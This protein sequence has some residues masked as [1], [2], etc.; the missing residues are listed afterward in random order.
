MFRKS[1]S[2]YAPCALSLGLT[3][4]STGSRAQATY[5]FTFPTPA[6]QVNISAW[7]GNTTPTGGDPVFHRPV[8]GIGTTTTPTILSNTL[9]ASYTPYRTKNFTVGTGSSAIGTPGVYTVTTTGT[10]VNGPLPNADAPIGLIYRNSFNPAS[11]LTNLVWG[12]NTTPTNVTLSAGNYVFVVTTGFSGSSGPITATLT[13]PPVYAAPTATLTGTTAAP[14]ASALFNRPFANG[15]LPPTATD[16]TSGSSHYY[17]ADAFTVPADGLYELDSTAQTPAPWN[18]AIALYQGSFDPANPLTNCLEVS[19][20]SYSIAAPK[21]FSSLQYSLKAGVTYY[22]VTFAFTNTPG[23][24]G[25][26]VSTVSPVTLQTS[27]QFAGKPVGLL[28]T[29]TGNTTSQLNANRPNANSTLGGTLGAPP[30]TLSGSLVPADPHS[31]TSS[32]SGPV[33][34]TSTC[35][36]P[37][38]WNNWL[39]VYAGSFDISNP[40]TNILYSLDG[41]YSDFSTSPI[42]YAS[43]GVFNSVVS[44]TFNA[45]AGQVYTI[46]TTGNAAANVGSYRGTIASAPVLGAPVASFSGTLTAGSGGFG[47][48]R[49]NAG[50]TPSTA[51][52]TTSNFVIPSDFKSFTITTEG[53]YYITDTAVTPGQWSLYLI[54]YKDSFDGASP[55]TNAIAAVGADVNNV[56]ATIP[57]IH[58]TPGTY[59]AVTSGLG[60]S[61]VGSYAVSVQRITDNG[62]RFSYSDT[63]N[64]GTGPTTKVPSVSAPTTQYVTIFN[65]YTFGN[66]PIF[67]YYDTHSFTVPTTGAYNL[68][69][70]STGSIPW[71]NYTVL[72]KNSFDPNAPL[73][74]AI[75]ADETINTTGTNSGFRNVSL[76][77][78]TTYVLVVT[79]SRLYNF[80]SYHANLYTGGGNYPPLIPDN[81]P[82]GLSA[83]K[84]VT[85]TFTV[86][87]LDSVTIN[88]LYHPRIGD[89]LI[90]LSHGGTT[91]ELADRVGRTVSTSGV[92]GSI[93]LLNGDYTFQD[94]GA[95]LLD[96]VSKTPAGAA[97]E[98][99]TPFA[100]YTN[101]TPGAS[102]NLTGDFSAF[103]G[104]PVTGDWTLN[105][106]DLNNGGIGYYGGF[107]FMVNSTASVSGTIAFDGISP[108]AKPQDVRFIFTPTDGSAVITRYISVGPDGVFKVGNLPL[109]AYSLNVKSYKYLAKNVASVNITGGNVTGLAIALPG[110]DANNDN[111]IDIGDFGIL[112]NVYGNTYDQNSS[113]PPDINSTLP[114]DPNAQ[115]DFNGDGTIDIADFGILV[116]N[117]GNTG[118]M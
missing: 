89:L 11:P 65:P 74:N 63:L 75:V 103:N 35:T 59:Y 32:V 25:D 13:Q 81:V 91:I 41:G 111:T 33:T 66:D 31:W 114:A 99:T 43:Q 54:L 29:W 30:T 92:T 2:R 62:I 83:T 36:N 106:A 4:L 100:P 20:P 49:P 3:L 71:N 118:D 109:K 40:L 104:M 10:L 115:A 18:N 1:L 85:D 56:V 94:S 112:V 39:L 61:S 82:A 51:P 77:A 42:F 21:G 34:V 46:V 23:N 12:E 70:T 76:T 97:I 55:L 16:G 68:D 117:Y 6:N 90:T 87:S 19:G 60:S 80:G 73:T 53:D 98:S 22:F 48:K 58:L 105:I 79:G 47:Y 108:T 93:T 7:D 27:G 72:Y 14:G 37:A 8:V 24:Q 101:T 86:K 69:V 96:T 45:D 50:A 88:N 17:H 28:D 52:T 44:V 26:Y 78:N 38:S 95:D 15:N 116:N 67:A 9:G 57:S 110:G 64:G 5:S 107:T 113:L 102:S 84:T